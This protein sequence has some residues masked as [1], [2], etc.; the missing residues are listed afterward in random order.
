MLKEILAE[1]VSKYT[2]HKLTTVESNFKVSDAA[3]AMAESKI[4]SILVSEDNDIIGI[5]TNKDIISDVVAKGKNP[6]KIIVKEIASKPVIKIHKDSKVRD[7]IELMNKHDIRRLLVYNDE[8]PVGII[9]RKLLVGNMG[10]FATALPELELPERYTCPYCSS[11][12]QNKKTLSS[13]I[14][15]IHIGKGLLEGNIAKAQ[16]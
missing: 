12:F 13:H 1:P 7:A 2:N 4:D 6:S 9:S 10:E 16:V 5:V 3:K 11:V 8:R 15:G 14:D